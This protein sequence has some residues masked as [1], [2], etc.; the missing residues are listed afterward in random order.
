MTRGKGVA[1]SYAEVLIIVRRSAPI[2]CPWW[3][4]AMRTSENRPSET[5]WKS[6]KCRSM[7]YAPEHGKVLFDRS[8]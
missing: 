4:G 1:K 5:V 6:E 8:F 3:T 2:Q 7:T